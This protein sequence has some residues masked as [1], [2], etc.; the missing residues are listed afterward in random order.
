MLTR[1]LTRLLR[2]LFL[3]AA[4]AGGIF[5][6]ARGIIELYARPR[7]HASSASPGA[8]VAIVFGAGLYRDGTPTPVLRD[9]VATAA[10]LYFNG[11]VEKLLMSGDNRFVYYNEPE[12]MRQYALQLGVP[13]AD[14]VLDYAGRRTYDTCYRAAA[15]FGVPQAVLV[16]QRFHLARAVFTCNLLGLPATG[17]SADRRVYRR[18]SEI[19]WNLREIP[20]SLVALW[21]VLIT[22]PKPVLGRPEPIF[23]QET[24]AISSIRGANT[25]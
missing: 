1:F 25:P 3:A 22:R 24:S 20:A 4:A 15:I 23:A 10:E 9:R 11:K 7:I 12:A 19:I 13:D 21:E 2:M 14:I 16:T 8:R 6:A 5:L 17:A 18:S